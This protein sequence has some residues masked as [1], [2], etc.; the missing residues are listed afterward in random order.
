MRSISTLD[1]HNYDFLPANGS[2]LQALCAACKSGYVRVKLPANRQVLARLWA[3][4]E[5]PAMWEE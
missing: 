5:R 1:N 4:G 2:L 3:F